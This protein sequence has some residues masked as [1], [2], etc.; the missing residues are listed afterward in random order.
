MFV[1]VVFRPKSV[2]CSTTPPSAEVAEY[3][4][5]HGLSD[6]AAGLQGALAQ[7]QPDDPYLF[8]MQYI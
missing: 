5:A 6:F 8:M 2:T 4:A 3:V 7:Q 1:F